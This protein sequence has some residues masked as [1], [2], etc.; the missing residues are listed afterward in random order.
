MLRIHEVRWDLAQN[1]WFCNDNKMRSIFLD[2]KP[3]EPDEVP[4]WN[5]FTQ[6]TTIHGIRYIFNISHSTFRRY[7]TK[8]FLKQV[9]SRRVVK[10]QKHSIFFQVPRLIR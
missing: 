3:F 8:H 1:L 10:N 4:T 9:S 6:T 2:L 7:K 5:H